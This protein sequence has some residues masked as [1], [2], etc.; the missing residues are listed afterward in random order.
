MAQRKLCGGNIKVQRG[1]E[2]LASFY[3]FPFCLEDIYTWDIV[4]H[5]FVIFPQFSVAFYDFLFC[6]G[7]IYNNRQDDNNNNDEK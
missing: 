7:D 5:V 6:L 3:D 1:C 4:K 2:I